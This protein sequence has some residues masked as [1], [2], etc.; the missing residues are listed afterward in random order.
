MMKKLKKPLLIILIALASLLLLAVLLGVLNATVGGGEWTFGW[1]DY[2]YDDGGYSV[3]SATVYAEGITALDVDW[4][5]GTVE[6][7]ICQD[8]YPSV[9]ERVSSDASESTQMRHRVSDDGKTLLIK[10]RAPSVF[11][12]NGTEEGKH[13]I[14]RIPERMLSQ[15]QSLRI[16]AVS[17]EIVVDDIPFA[18]VVAE[19][20]SGDVTLHLGTQTRQAAV[21]ARRG[22]VTLLVDQAPSFS[23]SYESDKNKTPTLD[24]FCERI[25][26]KY[27]C[28][29]GKSAV[30]VHTADG[31]LWVAIKKS[32]R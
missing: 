23:L 12:G 31:E 6:I 19:S 21:T 30:S 24:V 1:T 25:D 27:V 10:H 15:M 5:D 11:F 32:N 26:G 13:L 29:E 2:R 28:G 4:L 20:R 16:K 18:E 14:V 7:V 9:S 22:D 8:Y 17:A 3:G